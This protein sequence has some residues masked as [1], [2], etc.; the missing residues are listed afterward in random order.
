MTARGSG[1]QMRTIKKIGLAW[2]LTLPATM[3]VSA[4]LFYILS[5]YLH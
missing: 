2:V 4:L 3:A 5:R 1:V